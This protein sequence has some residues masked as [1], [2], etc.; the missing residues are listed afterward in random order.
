MFVSA[1]MRR[2]FFNKLCA[3]LYDQNIMH[4]PV[5][6]LQGFRPMTKM[7]C[8]ALFYSHLLGC[9]KCL[10]VQIPYRNFYTA[11]VL[12]Q[13]YVCH[14]HACLPFQNPRNEFYRNRSIHKEFSLLL[15]FCMPFGFHSTHHHILSLQKHLFKEL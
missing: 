13:L 14:S 12:L 5:C 2:S 6:Y 8:A 9:I 11:K 3:K 15:L 10:V 4:N 7:L 1:N